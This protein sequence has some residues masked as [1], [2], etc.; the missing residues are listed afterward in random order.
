MALAPAAFRGAKFAVVESQSAGGRRVA[1]HQYPGKEVPWAED[2]GR[3][4]RRF[5]LRGFVLDGSVKLGRGSVSMQ[6]A[7][8]MT[9]CDKRGPG[10]LDHPTLGKITVALQRWTIGEGLDAQ[11]YSEVEI[12]AVETGQ[13]EYPAVTATATTNLQKQVGAVQFTRPLTPA[14]SRLRKA[15][16]RFVKSTVLALV[17]GKPLTLSGVL[18]S[19]TGLLSVAGVRADLVGRISGWVSRVLWYANDATALYRIA[20]GLLAS[21][22]FTYGRYAQGAN[23]GLTTT[24]PSAYANDQTITDLNADASVLRQEVKD[25][26]QACADLAASVDLADITP[27]GEAATDMIDALLDCCA[28]PADAIRILLS[29]LSTTLA[30]ASTT[31]TTLVDLMVCEAAAAALT[32]AV[33]RYQPSSTDDAAARIAQIG[34]VLDAL[35]VAAADAGADEVHAALRDCRAAI[36]TMLRDAAAT[37]ADL[38]NFAFGEPLPALLIAQQ[39][40]G[41][42]ARADQLVGQVN[43]VNPLFFPLAFEALAS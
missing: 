6:R 17:S 22:G 19:A 36:V 9:A 37:V 15:L 27:L 38:Q 34:P 33:S 23:S 7:A 3:D 20:A 32:D 25:R 31:I 29:L 1:L 18:A 30:G 8:L 16:L 35:A 39:I 28:D 21:D 5:R 24:N 14:G 41:D 11:N 10:T 40:Y 13:Q 12:E 2:M 43:P 4:A 26:A 42:A